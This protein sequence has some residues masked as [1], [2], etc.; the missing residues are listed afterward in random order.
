MEFYSPRMYPK[1]CHWA[2]TNS[3][4]FEIS[5]NG[6]VLASSSFVDG[7]G[8]NYVTVGK[9]TAGIYSMKITTSFNMAD[10]YGYTAKVYTNQKVDIVKV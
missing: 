10:V 1:G 6:A 8:F 3:A 2:G 7:T 9:S 5:K 4:K